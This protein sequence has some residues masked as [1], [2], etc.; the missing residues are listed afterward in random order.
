MNGRGS[1]GMTKFAGLMVAIFGLMAGPG[2]A[3]L[4]F[5]DDPAKGTLTITDGATP[6]LT[7]RYGDQLKPG[8]DPAQTRSC[9]IHPL[10]S[11]D[12]RELTDDFPA[13]TSITTES[14]GAGRWS[15][16]AA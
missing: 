10:Y 4:K 2:L 7:Y 13:T 1:S 12:G 16:S 14:S 8:V 3:Q 6:V 15:R 9:Y 5:V 11:L